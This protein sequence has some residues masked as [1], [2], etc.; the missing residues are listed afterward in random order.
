MGRKP[1]LA[2]LQD[3]P[4]PGRCRVLALTLP[5]LLLA[6]AA[7]QADASGTG[8]RPLQLKLGAAPAT[9]LPARTRVQ[10]PA[11]HVR[12]KVAEPGL[13][14]RALES[15]LADADSQAEASSSSPS[16]A[17]FRFERRG[18]VGRDLAQGYN[19]MCDAVSRKVWDDP[20]GKRLKFDVA[21]KPGV[22]VEIP[23]R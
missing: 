6:C 7:G 11:R 21:G 5:A 15:L 19:A 14:Q 4:M 17:T 18:H 20:N 22:G 9:S 12:F 16:G 10:G 1:P 2:D 8:K 23:L 3:P 13:S